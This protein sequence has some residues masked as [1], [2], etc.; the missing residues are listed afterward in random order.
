MRIACLTAGLVG[1]AVTASSGFASDPG[2]QPVPVP[3]PAPCQ[4]RGIDELVRMTRC[5]L[6]TLYRQAD[7]GTPPAGVTRGRAI[8]NPGS[9]VT[10]PAARVTRVLWQ[11]KVFKDDGMMVNRVFGMRAI[12]ARIYS[13]ESWLDG[14]PALILD[15][16]GASKLFPNVRDEVREVAPGLY[17]G[18]TYLRRDGPPKLAMFFALDARNPR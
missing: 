14:R 15:Y 16:C 17:V 6:E 10:V 9:P 7:P 13:G 18:L 4:V 11:G 3:C 8:F 1:L 5:E 12:H 2:S